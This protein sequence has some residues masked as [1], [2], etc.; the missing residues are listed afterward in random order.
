MSSTVS[1]VYYTVHYYYILPL[2]TS[3]KT[4]LSRP[5]SITRTIF[6]SENTAFPNM[7]FIESTIMTVNKWKITTNIS[8][9]D[10]LCMHYTIQTN[11]ETVYMNINN[12]SQTTY[13]FST[14]LLEFLSWN[15]LIHI[16]HE[17]SLVSFKSNLRE[18]ENIY[19]LALVLSIY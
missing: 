19:R 16:K 8:I 15:K 6:T 5:S 11:R 7:F 14:S 4:K 13:I 3:N 12:K 18:E 9:I 10:I 17:T 1:T 2:S